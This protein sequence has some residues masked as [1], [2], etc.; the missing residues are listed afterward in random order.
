MTRIKLLVTALSLGT[1]FYACEAE[2]L[3][4]SLDTQNG[5]NFSLAIDA[6]ASLSETGE[7]D[8]EV[9]GKSG[10]DDDKPG[11]DDGRD[12]GDDDDKPGMDDGRDSGDDDDKPGMDDGRSSGDDDDKPGMDDSESGDDDDKPGMDDGRFSG[13]DDDKPGMD[14]N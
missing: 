1:L 10:D 3:D 2:S 12:S 8:S 13:D 7:Q 6:D 4:E 5:T 11:M 14:D 9:N